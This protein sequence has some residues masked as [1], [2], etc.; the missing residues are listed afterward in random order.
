MRHLPLLGEE[1]PEWVV[2][3]CV[4][5]PPGGVICGR[6]ATWHGVVLDDEAHS[7]VA[8]ME[9]CDEHLDRMKLTADYIHRLQHP[10][11]IDGSMFRWPENYCYTAWDEASEFPQAAA[12]SQS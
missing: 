2:E 3:L 6:D 10:C 11:G 7:I 9:S 8:T 1:A 4:H 12:V 5:K